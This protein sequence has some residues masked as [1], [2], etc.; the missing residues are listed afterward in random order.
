MAPVH[1]LPSPE[2]AQ[3][4]PIVEPPH[5]KPRKKFTTNLSPTVTDAVNLELAKL[6]QAGKKQSAA[7][8][9]EGYLIEW[10]SSRGVNV[11]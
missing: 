2:I 9:I 4:E 6:Q 7:D 11:T 1:E 5:M 3:A 10:L 8:L